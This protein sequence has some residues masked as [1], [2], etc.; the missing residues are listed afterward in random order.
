M[1]VLSEA[2]LDKALMVPERTMDTKQ[3]W[4]T[5]Y[6]VIDNNY[7]EQSNLGFQNIYY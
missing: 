4:K 1:E 7:F 6:E 2:E 3:P 5:I